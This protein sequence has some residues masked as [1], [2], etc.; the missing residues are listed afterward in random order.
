MTERIC[1]KCG[2]KGHTT[3]GCTVKKEMRARNKRLRAEGKEVKR[4][5]SYGRK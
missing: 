4:R 1:K 3:R 5:Q 2:E